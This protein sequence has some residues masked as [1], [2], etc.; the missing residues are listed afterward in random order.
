[1]MAAD[2]MVGLDDFTDNIGI[3]NCVRGSWSST[4]FCPCRCSSQSNPEVFCNIL[5]T[6]Q[7]DNVSKS[8]DDNAMNITCL[9]IFFLKCHYHKMQLFL[10]CLFHCEW[11]MYMPIADGSE[12]F[13]YVIA[14]LCAQLYTSIYTILCNGTNCTLHNVLYTLWSSL[15]LKKLKTALK[16]YRDIAHN[17]EACLDK[18]LF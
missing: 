12:I 9:Y 13:G 5:Y 11:C 14:Y 16:D 6:T 17:T 18:L 1:M 8:L 2:M 10:R 3:F 4:S 7:A 15:S